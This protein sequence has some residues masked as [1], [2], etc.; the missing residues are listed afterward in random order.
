MGQW[1]VRRLPVYFSSPPKDFG[2]HCWFGIFSHL[3]FASRNK[4]PWGRPKDCEEKNAGCP[5]FVV[6]S[7]FYKNNG[8]KCYLRPSTKCFV[9]FRVRR[10]SY[11]SYLSLSPALLQLL[12]HVARGL[13]L[14]AME[15][16]IR[17]GNAPARRQGLHGVEGLREDV[18][19]QQG[20]EV[21]VWDVFGKMII[22]YIHNSSL[23]SFS[24]I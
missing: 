13:L 9:Q 3:G 22:I 6:P 17:G 5:G 4:N 15:G 12:R 1:A 11:S 14:A 10:A 18:R 19:P 7:L 16:R 2:E 20:S 8:R 24:F 21:R 23:F